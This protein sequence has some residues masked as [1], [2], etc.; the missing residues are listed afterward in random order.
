MQQL[1][2]QQ[3]PQLTSQYENGW[4]M[5]RA[6][7]WHAN[8]LRPITLGGTVYEPM[9]HSH[10]SILCQKTPLQLRDSSPTNPLPSKCC[11]RCLEI[12]V[13]NQVMV[14]MGVM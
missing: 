2:Q 7:V 8:R 12:V 5:D 10:R 6:G 4:I 11:R 1:P 3:L 13:T 14:K 9:P